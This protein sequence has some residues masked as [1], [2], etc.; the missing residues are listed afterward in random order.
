MEQREIRELGEGDRAEALKA[1]EELLEES[2]HFLLELAPEEEWSSYVERLG[3]LGR[4]EGVPEG[5]VPASFHVLLVEE[6]VVGR[7]SIRHSLNEQLHKY[8]GHIGYAVRPGWRRRG[9]ASMLLA[10]GLEVCK[11]KGVGNVLVTCDEE[12]EGSRRTIEKA[13]GVLED[14][15][16]DP[17]GPAKRR[18]WIAL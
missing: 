11:E 1:H 2:F 5:R 12:N 9:Y 8:G 16:P 14:I 18:Y 17:Q 6:R 4:G 10:H 3:K 13:G 7:V 15:Q